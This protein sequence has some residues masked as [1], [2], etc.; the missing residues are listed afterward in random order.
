VLLLCSHSIAAQIVAIINCCIPLIH[1]CAILL[2][3]LLQLLLLLLVVNDVSC[4][5][6][7]NFPDSL[8]LKVTASCP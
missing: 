2:L 7:C 3:L 6:F 5:F 4:L 8:Q 1:L